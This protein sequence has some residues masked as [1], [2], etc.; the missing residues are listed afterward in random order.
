M[1]I[2]IEIK[3]EGGATT[4]ASR[5]RIFCEFI[6]LNSCSCSLF[7]DLETY[8]GWIQRHADCLKN[9]KIELSKDTPEDQNL[10]L[11]PEDLYN[12]G[13]GYPTKR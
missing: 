9:T 13:L 6:N 4:C 8:K 7:G 10:N 12:T 5:P 3:I 11:T 2:K 1:K